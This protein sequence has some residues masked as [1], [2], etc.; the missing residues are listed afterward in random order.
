MKGEHIIQTPDY[1]KGLL[2]Q[3]QSQSRLTPIDVEVSE[4]FFYEEV[5][6]CETIKVVN[7]DCGP[8]WCSYTVF[9]TSKNIP[10]Y[11]L[12]TTDYP[13]DNNNYTVN[14]GK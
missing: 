2:I 8:V 3:T 9:D 5:E 13:G 14:D 4:P 6:W 1:W 7:I 11:Q 10:E 12:D